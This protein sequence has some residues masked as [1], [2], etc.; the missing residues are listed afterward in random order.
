MLEWLLASVSMLVIGKAIKATDKAKYKASQ[1][2]RTSYAP[3]KPPTRYQNKCKQM[4]YEVYLKDLKENPQ[5]A[6]YKVKHNGYGGFVFDDT[7]Y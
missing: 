3:P 1:Q 2:Q 6:A 4:M 7:E 5:W